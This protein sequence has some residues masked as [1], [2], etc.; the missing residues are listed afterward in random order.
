[1]K[2]SVQTLLP[3]GNYLNKKYGIEMDFPEGSNIAENFKYLNDAVTAI[4]MAECPAFYKD[5]KPLYLPQSA[6]TATYSGEEM[7]KEIQVKESEPKLSKEERQKKCITDTTTIE[8]MDGLKS[9]AL[10]VSKNPHLQEIYDNHLKKLTD[11]L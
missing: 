1:M 7:P 5:G 2:L 8:G 4:H 6:T 10:L 3:T 11:G 9:F